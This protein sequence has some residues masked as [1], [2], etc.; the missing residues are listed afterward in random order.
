[1]VLFA[2][3]YR[4]PVAPRSPIKA[5]PI[6][7]TSPLVSGSTSIAGQKLT[8]EITPVF[9]PIPTARIFNRLVPHAFV[10]HL[11][12]D[13]KSLYWTI[14]RGGNLFSYPFVS[15]K[16]ADVSIIAKTNFTKGVLS[17][18]PRPSFF[19]VGMWLIFDDRRITEQAQ[20]WVLRAI[21]LEKQTEQ[22]IAQ[23]EGSTNLYTFSSDG[24][25]VVWITGDL[26]IGTIITAQNL[27][28]GQRRELARSNSNRTPW[29][30][31]VVSAGRAVASQLNLNGRSLF[32]FELK[33]G[34]SQKVPIDMPG[35]DMYGLTFDG[36]WIAWK[37]GT[38]SYGSTALY[39]LQATKIE[40]LPDWGIAPL[41]VGRWLTWNAAFE[42]PLYVID[43]ENRQ[44]FIVAEAQTGDN[45]T[46]VAIYGNVIAWCRVHTD[47]TDHT[48]IDSSVEWRTLP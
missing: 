10:N 23:G 24:E 27:Q 42:Q 4:G 2:C 46:D 37:T 18:Y 5:L 17:N 25:W 6:A 28:T 16:K 19:R 30:Q 36:N 35:S 3:G 29:E 20:V 41:L 32:L 26:S 33:S 39:N 7:P 45:L 43:L 12:L 31:V 21:N 22:N 9:L 48:K 38:N 8:I 15:S 13:D 14:E 44:N 11:A 40:I 1:M 34:Q 47:L